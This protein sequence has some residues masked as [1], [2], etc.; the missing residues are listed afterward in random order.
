VKAADKRTHDV[1]QQ[2]TN[3]LLKDLWILRVSIFG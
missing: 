1:N 3:K 2:R